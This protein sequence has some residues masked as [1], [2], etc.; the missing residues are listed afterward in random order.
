[1]MSQ[2]E[3][4][5]IKV[6]QI[7]FIFLAFMPATKISLL[8]SVLAGFADERLW[9][10]ALIGFLFD[11]LTLLVIMTL[12]KKHDNCTLYHILESK[13]SP[14]VAKAVYFGYGVYFI[15]KALVTLLEQ[16]D[17]IQD[18]LYEIK[19]SS[20][21]FL[22]FFLLSFY[23][24]L[25][26]LKILGRCADACIYLTATGLLLTF[27]LSV[28]T[29]DFS[30]ML[31][32][33]Q[34]PTYK[35]VIGVFKSV[36]WFSDS[37]YALLFLGHFKAEKRQTV[38]ITLSYAAASVTVIFFMIV[39][40]S[41]FGSVADTRFF[42]TPELTIYSLELTNSTRIDYLAIFLLMFSQVFAITMP[43]YL[44]TKCFE[45]VFNLKKAL[46]PA[47]I[48]N[49][50]LAAFTFVFRGKLFT[51]LNIFSTYFSYVF[52]F[53]GYLLPLLLLFIPKET[54]KCATVL[55]TE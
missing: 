39:F 4:N 27:L 10:S 23:Q 36:I 55:S 19:P 15:L 16:Q 32:I 5:K 52:I 44:S 51:V 45:R 22:P 20:F 13:V 31:P 30:N 8:P 12:A 33:I 2:N 14:F 42:A 47:I 25:K 38:K 40:Y 11:L 28:P 43:I 49:L 50:F 54:T 1:M 53:F 21:V 26:G 18:T 24:S 48:I 37:V 46:F 34:K 9:V 29:A 7:C 35:P 6:R 3:K 17:Y 41:A